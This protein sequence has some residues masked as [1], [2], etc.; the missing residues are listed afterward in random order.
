MLTPFFAAACEEKQCP[1][2]TAPSA[3]S[4]ASAAHP[5]TDEAK[6]FVMKVDEDLKKVVVANSRAQWAYQ[7]NITDDTEAIA[8]AAEEANAAYYPK[9]ISEA[10]RFDG[11]ILPDD[12]KRQL[13]LLKIAPTIPAPDNDAER[14]ELAA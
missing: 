3:A 2:A 1:P 13:H 11:L 14:S 5:T 6:K 10:K 7:T 12:V 4:S 9:A 8:T